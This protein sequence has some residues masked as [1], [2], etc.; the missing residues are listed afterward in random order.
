M[1]NHEQRLHVN[2]YPNHAARSVVSKQ[3]EK[4]RKIKIG[5]WV[6]FLLLIFEGGLRKWVLPG[7]ATPLLIIRDPVALYLIYE[8]TRL[9]LLPFNLS[10]FL[11]VGVGLIGSLI[12][13]FFG[14][15]N[16]WVA[17]YGARIFILHFP[18]IYVIGNVLTRQDIIK[19]AKVTLIISIPMI[20]LLA[21]Q[22]YSPQSAFVN[23]G[24]GGDERG[25]GF[26][27]ALGYRRPPGTFSFTNGTTL[28]F[29]FLAPFIFYFW[30]NTQYV[31]RWILIASTMALLFSIPLSI[32][33]ALF[34]SVVI[35]AFMAVIAVARKPKY[36]TRMIGA[37]IGISIVI[38][39]LSQVSIFQTALEAFTARFEG[40]NE[41]EGGFQSVIVDRYL[42]GLIGAISGSDRT[43]FWG[44]GI[45]ALTNIGQNLLTFNSDTLF[46]EGEWGR[47]LA[48]L[49]LILGL[50]V[51]IIRTG[52]AFRL[53]AKCFNRLRSGDILPWLMCGY[54]L[55]NLPQ[56]QWKQPTAL[57]FCIMIA[58]LVMASINNNRVII[59]SAH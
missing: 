40:A 5:I 56:G 28:F 37:I 31:K 23:R 41:S 22:F 52:L 1:S 44:Y 33:R 54:L 17:I 11:M 2:K 58:G 24:V 42:G 19:M 55:L 36:F 18:V 57:G 4:T 43:P 6:Y 38:F 21:L 20:I 59:P 10:V 8:A 46:I 14:H 32:S 47:T 26:S 16:L 30:F 15:G 12:A 13:M 3:L 7:L 9:K 27:G 49:G 29:S 51:I 53:A 39:V 34:L 50:L 35:S 25:A 45:G 48:E